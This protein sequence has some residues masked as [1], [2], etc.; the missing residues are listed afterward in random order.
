MAS[1]VMFIK[2]AYMNSYSKSAYLINNS[3]TL[4]KRKHINYKAAMNST[5]GICKKNGILAHRAASS[6]S[7]SEALWDQG[8]N[9]S[10]YLTFS[11]C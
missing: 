6:H 3:S 9:I 11:F 10:L 5:I 1:L 7:T 4:Y 8:N 2:Y